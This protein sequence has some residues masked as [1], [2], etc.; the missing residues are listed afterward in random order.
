MDVVLN[1]FQRVF[2]EEITWRYF[3]EIKIKALQS[4]RDISV[5]WTRACGDVIFN[6]LRRTGRHPPKSISGP[7]KLST[8]FLP[9]GL[10]IC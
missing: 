5:Q 9:T 10:V 2:L 8:E 4:G 1:N 7:L 3:L 6:S